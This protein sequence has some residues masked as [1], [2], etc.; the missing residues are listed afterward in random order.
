MKKEILALL[1]TKFVGVS[2]QVLSRIADKLAKTA[3]TSELVTTAVEGVTLQNV[4]DSYTDSRATEATNSAVGNYEK[5]HGLKDGLK[6]TGGESLKTE[7][8][9][10]DDDNTP[11]WAKALLDSNKALTDKVAAME[12]VKQ[13]EQFST[14]LKDKCKDIDED[15][16]GV[17]TNGRTFTSEE[18]VNTFA[19]GLNSQW[20]AYS[21]RLANEGLSRMG[22]PSGGGSPK[23]GSEAIASMI[24]SGTKQIVES[25]N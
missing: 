22:K 11:P 3:T 10:P 19:E 15:F 8:I 20:G 9:I 25:K 16:Y 23:E 18:D 21:Q 4:I 14:I 17:A 6:T 7:P 1:I 13:S 12:G 5:K 2:E 24:D